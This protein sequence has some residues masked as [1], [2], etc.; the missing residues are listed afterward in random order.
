[1]AGRVVVVGQTNVF[2]PPAWQMMQVLGSERDRWLTLEPG[3]RLPAEVDAGPD[4]VRWASPWPDRPDDEILIEVTEDSLGS[5]LRWTLLS[6]EE[7]RPDEDLVRERRH[8]LNSLLNERLRD[9]LDAE[10]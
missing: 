7:D 6:A 2:A 3:E 8:R 5:R 10:G 1:M 9:F 4:W